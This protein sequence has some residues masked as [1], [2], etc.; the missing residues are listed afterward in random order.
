MDF[1]DLGSPSSPTKTQ[2]Y[3]RRMKAEIMERERPPPVLPSQPSVLPRTEMFVRQPEFGTGG[4]LPDQG[5]LRAV[6]K[7]VINFI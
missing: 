5:D 4:C 1:F 3:G 2:S 6:S 7:D